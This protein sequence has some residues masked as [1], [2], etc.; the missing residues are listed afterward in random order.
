M[1]LYRIL[2]GIVLIPIVL[3]I[4]YYAHFY[5]FLAT[6]VLIEIIAFYE[7]IKMSQTGSIKINK[8]FAF[9]GISLLAWHMVIPQ[10]FIFTG[11]FLGCVFFI[12][13]H[14]LLKRM[15]FKSEFNT[16]VSTLLKT[17][18]VNFLS[19]IYIG[20]FLNYAVLLRKI[21]PHM[22]L[23]PLIITW[24]NDTGAY[25]IGRLFGKHKLAPK[26]SPNKTWEGSIAGICS[27]MITVAIFKFAVNGTKF[28][29]DI[30]YAEFLLAGIIISIAG[31]IGDL[32]ESYIKRKCKVKD[33]GNLIPGH[34]GLL[35]RIDSLIFSLPLTYYFFILI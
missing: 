4:I 27:G 24:A 28:F 11:L 9:A 32:F 15:R 6:I 17:V 18:G 19:V 7:L 5:G 13:T 35:D 22:I 2:S 26:I 34:G 3:L 31:Q 10:K 20:W 21:S 25:A 33:S 8:G 23:F 12:F 1:L 14:D 16:P 30:S 29:T